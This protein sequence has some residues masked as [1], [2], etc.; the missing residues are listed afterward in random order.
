MLGD[1]C[2]GKIFV[3]YVSGKHCAFLLVEERCRCFCCIKSNNNN[4]VIYKIDRSVKLSFQVC[5]LD[6]VY[7]M[8]YDFMIFCPLFSTATKIPFRLDLLV[9]FSFIFCGCFLH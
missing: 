7:D 9:F 3:I 2:L 8:Y 4:V 1:L 5:E 6:S